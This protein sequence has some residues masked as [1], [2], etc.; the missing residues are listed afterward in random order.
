MHQTPRRAVLGWKFGLED[1]KYR[2]EA[3]R[4]FGGQKYRREP[5]MVLG[6]W[7]GSHFF[8]PLM[9]FRGWESGAGTASDP[10]PRKV[11]LEDPKYR[12]E[13]VFGLG[14]KKYRKE[15]VQGVGNWP[16]DTLRGNWLSGR[17]VVR[18]WH[19]RAPSSYSV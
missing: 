4:G 15:A 9:Q 8:A 14:T 5:V 6:I 18:S 13:A 11:G 17:A 16:W 7:P 1:P 12:R 3:V 19:P 10:P 2:R